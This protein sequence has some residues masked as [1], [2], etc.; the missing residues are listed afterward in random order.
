MNNV[1][2]M[3]GEET[4]WG[5]DTDSRLIQDRFQ[6]NMRDNLSDISGSV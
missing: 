5:L 6:R 4:I 3:L 2:K 1:Y